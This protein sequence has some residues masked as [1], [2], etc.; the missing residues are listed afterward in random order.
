MVIHLAGIVSFSLK[1]KAL[2]EKVNI[3]GTK[4]M[5]LAAKENKVKQFIH[6]SSVAA[7]GYNDD[8]ENPIDED[9]KFDWEIAKRKKKYYMLTKHL[10]DVEIEKNKGSLNTVVLYPG[11]MFGPGDKT[12]SG[13]LISA[14][15]EHRHC[16]DKKGEG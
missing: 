11:L 7:L 9:F 10:A 3:E 1:D 8:P 6:I 5:L 16:P 14:I 12:N 13:R 4:N 15:K 2:L